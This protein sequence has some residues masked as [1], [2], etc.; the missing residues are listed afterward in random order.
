M[1]IEWW[2][3]LALTLIDVIISFFIFTGALNRSVY[4]LSGWYKVGLIA[5][6]FG[7]LSQAA[8]N[9]PFLVLG[10]RIF[11]NTLP[12]WILKDIGIFII[13][14]LYIIKSREKEKT[15]EKD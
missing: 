5:I 3:F 13:A 9:L 1:S 12:F 14:F 10:K 4:S 8:L 15:K 7:S 2:G 6:A 11:S